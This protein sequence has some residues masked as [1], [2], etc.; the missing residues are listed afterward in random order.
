[1]FHEWIQIAGLFV[2]SWLLLRMLAGQ[3]LYVLGWMPP[4][5]MIRYAIILLLITSLSASLSFVLRIGIAQEKYILNAGFR[6]GDLLAACWQTFRSVLTE[7]LLFRGAL[8]Y[9][10]LQRFGAKP[11]VGITAVL[12]AGFHWLDPKLW[13]RP[14]EFILVFLFTFLMGMV[15]ATAFVRTQ[16]IWIPILIHLAWNLVQQV[17]FPVMPGG[18]SVFVLAA[19]PPVVTISYFELFIL[20]FLP[21]LLVVGLNAWILYRMKPLR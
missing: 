7:E 15:L 19:E 4:P 14:E 20:L 1:M 12:F 6:G 17:L 11:A 3:S 18:V 13:T 2:I 10:L 9:I 5:Q 8:L 16:T 21:K